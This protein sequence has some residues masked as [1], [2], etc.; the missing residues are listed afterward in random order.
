LGG[1][2][3]MRFSCW[4]KDSAGHWHVARTLGSNSDNI[5]WTE[6]HMQVA[7]PLHRAATWLEVVVTSMSGRVRATVPLDW[8]TT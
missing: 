3:D 6:L 7:P 2:L 8:T 1:G 5:S 4:I